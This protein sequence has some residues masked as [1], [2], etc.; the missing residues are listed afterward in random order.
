M[1][2]SGARRVLRRQCCQ[3]VQRLW[4]ALHRD[5][6]EAVRIPARG[7]CVRPGGHPGNIPT[8]VAGSARLLLYRADREDRAVE[9]ELAGGGDPVAPIHVSTELLHQAEGECEAGGRAADARRVDAD[10][11]WKLADRRAGLVDEDPDRGGLRVLEAPDC[12]D[13]GRGRP[14]TVAEPEPQP[15]ALA[16]R[17]D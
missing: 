4:K 10:R 15:V 17:G 11:D 6:S 14:V 12:P 3:G 5:D 16:M 1:A 9:L 8:S 2:R 13:R 7:A